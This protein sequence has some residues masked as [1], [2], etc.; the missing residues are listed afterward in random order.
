MR[1]FEFEDLK[2]WQKSV[3]FVDQI[4]HLLETLNSS[5]QHYRLTEQIESASASISANIAE[6]KGRNSDKDYL[7]FLYY[8]RGSLYET[9]TFLEVM[10]RRNWIIEQDYQNIRQDAIEIGKML[11]GLIRSIKTRLNE[12]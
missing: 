4:L 2:V 11:N 5:R 3:H 8:S 9:V 7:R 10:K 1:A 12:N 6:G